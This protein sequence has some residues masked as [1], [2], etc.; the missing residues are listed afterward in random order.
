ML[1]ASLSLLPW[2]VSVLVKLL[3]ANTIG[4]SA[5]LSGAS[6]LG[7]HIPSY[8]CPR[9]VHSLTPD[10]SVLGE[11]APSHFRMPWLYSF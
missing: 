2:Q 10:A 1:S 11:A 9:L 3:L 7:N 8:T 5:A 6:L 4:H